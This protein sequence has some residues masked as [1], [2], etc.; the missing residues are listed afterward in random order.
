MAALLAI[1][2]IVIRSF[3]NMTKTYLIQPNASGNSCCFDCGTPRHSL[4][5]Q[6]VPIGHF[7]EPWRCADSLW[8]TTWPSSPL[9]DSPIWCSLQMKKQ[10]PYEG[11]LEEKEILLFLDPLQ[12][13]VLITCS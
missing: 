3:L 6:F 2:T 9:H 7:L 13:C 1:L 12:C 11:V 4:H 5:R 10:E 8:Q